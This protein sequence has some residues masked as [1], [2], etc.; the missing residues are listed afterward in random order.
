MTYAQLDTTP[1]PSWRAIADEIDSEAQQQRGA[2]QELR[3]VLAPTLLKDK[4]ALLEPTR[5]AN[6]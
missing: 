4:L 6:P 3:N 1:P 2:L 5:E